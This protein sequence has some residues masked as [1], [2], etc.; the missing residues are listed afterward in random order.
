MEWLQCM[1]LATVTMKYLQ[2]AFFPLLS[3]QPPHRCEYIKTYCE[4]LFKKK[5]PWNPFTVCIFASAD[6]MESLFC[7]SDITALSSTF[8]RWAIY[9]FSTFWKQKRDVNRSEKYCQAIHPVVLS[10]N[11]A[12]M[13]RDI[14]IIF[15]LYDHCFCACCLQSQAAIAREEI[16][17]LLSLLLNKRCN[18][19]FNQQD[20]LWTSSQGELMAVRAVRPALA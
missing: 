13:W 16:L 4:E 6:K 9:S 17:F 1:L 3:T 12:L 2:F 15:V 14:I 19:F 11:A 7:P 5:Q 10:A 8:L 20:N 18:H